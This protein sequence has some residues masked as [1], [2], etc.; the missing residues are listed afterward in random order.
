MSITVVG[1]SS[2]AASAVRVLCCKPSVIS[3]AFTLN[4]FPP[5]VFLR[6]IKLGSLLSSEER[7]LE[8]RLALQ[9]TNS[10]NL[11]HQ[12]SVLRLSVNVCIVVI[13]TGTTQVNITRPLRPFFT[14]QCKFSRMC[15][16]VRG[17]H[18]FPEAGETTSAGLLAER[19]AVFPWYY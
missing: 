12:E 5:D 16:G 17:V 14:A 10:W 11:W 8:L 18:D 19:I 4:V 7:Q 15:N 1:V 6:G 2:S 9:L 13:A 3:S